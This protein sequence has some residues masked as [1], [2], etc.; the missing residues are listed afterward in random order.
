VNG[1]FRVCEQQA[2]RLN[3][4]ETEQRSKVQSSCFP[5]KG[6]FPMKSISLSFVLIL[7]LVPVAGAQNKPTEACRFPYD[8]WATPPE[9]KL[10]IAEVAQ[11]TTILAFC[12][13]KK[14]CSS[15]SASPGTPILIYKESGEWTCGYF[16]AYGGP[17]WIRRDDLHLVPYNPDPPLEGWVGTWAGGEERISIRPGKTPGTLRLEGS[18]Q[19]NGAGG[20]AHF[21]DL[22]GM[23]S[24]NGNRLHFVESGP[25]SCMVDMTL[26]GRYIVASDNGLCGALNAR[27]QGIWKRTGQ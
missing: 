7:A 14:G 5:G 19:W 6:E 23:A 27:F 8:G 4:S 20:N 15:S 13:S 22:K 21:G 9:Q 1:D 3:D 18:A 11:P 24:P 10:L 17:V 12:E 2:A 25:D 16:P 26:L